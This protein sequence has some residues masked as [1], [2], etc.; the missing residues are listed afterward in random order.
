MLQ[1]ESMS[2]LGLV[3]TLMPVLCLMTKVLVWSGLGIQF[4][5]LSP[6]GVS[7]TSPLLGLLQRQGPLCIRIPAL[8]TCPQSRWCVHGASLSKVDWPRGPME[9]I[10]G[11]SSVSRRLKVRA[12]RASFP[13][14]L[15]DESSQSLG[16][17]LPHRPLTPGRCTG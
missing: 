9:S 5:Q 2:R 1:L 12:V 16:R 8:C 7:L 4:P 3:C 13:R 10:S 15:S 6:M 11:A 14:A 17:I